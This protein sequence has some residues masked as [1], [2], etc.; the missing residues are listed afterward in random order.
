MPDT[1]V[2]INPSAGRLPPAAQSLLLN[3][4][5]WHSSICLGEVAIGVGNYNPASPDWD[6]SRRQYAGL[7][8]SIPE[9]RIR[10]PDE[11]TWIEAGLI[12][13]ILARTQGYQPHQRKECLNDALIYLSAAKEG[14]P[15]LTSNRDEFDV[16]QQIAKRGMFV[17]Y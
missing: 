9:T 11:Q 12:A 5:L 3:G 10:K 16:I 4:L 2:Y 13:G 15:V 1:N 17:H 8:A 7:I 14:I 6:A